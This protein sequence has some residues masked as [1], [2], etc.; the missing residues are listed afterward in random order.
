MSTLTED[1]VLR[2]LGTPDL[3]ELIFT[4]LHP[5]DV[6]HA[7]LVSRL[8]SSVIERPKFWRWSSTW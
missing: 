3:L 4:Y 8:W 7:R 6:K 1:P 5:A 2:V